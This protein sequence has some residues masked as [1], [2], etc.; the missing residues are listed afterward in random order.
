MNHTDWLETEYRLWEL[1]LGELMNPKA[2]KTFKSHPAVKRMLS[3]IE[4]GLFG[5]EL[6]PCT[7][8]L[9]Q[10]I[11]H[12]GYD[13]DGHMITGAAERMI[14]YAQQVLKVNPNHIVEIGGGVGQFYAIIRALGY[15]GKYHILDRYEVERFQRYYLSQ[16]EKETGLSLPLT[17]GTYDYCVSFYALGEFDDNLKRWYFEN[18]IDKAPHGLILYNPHSGANPAV[19]PSKHEFIITPEDPKTGENNKMIVW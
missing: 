14:H 9:L 16:V 15:K 2:F 1:A 11:D 10:K 3:D 6:D 8:M 4:R 18:V 5:L 17:P 7:E 13:T 12:I 19:P